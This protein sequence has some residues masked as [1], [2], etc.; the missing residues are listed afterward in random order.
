L[1]LSAEAYRLS[2]NRFFGSLQP[3]RQVLVI[4]GFGCGIELSMKSRIQRR[5]DARGLYCYRAVDVLGP[6]LIDLARQLRMTPA[7]VGDA[8]RRSEA[9]ARD[10]GYDLFGFAEFTGRVKSNCHPRI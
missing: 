6:S 1:F 3:V 5:A 4:F 8:V 2:F 10:Y 9:L 7:G